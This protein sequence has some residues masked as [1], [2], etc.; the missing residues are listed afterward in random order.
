VASP[1]SRTHRKLAGVRPLCTLAGET[2]RNPNSIPVSSS[3][4]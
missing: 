1:P 3:S 4:L 2:R